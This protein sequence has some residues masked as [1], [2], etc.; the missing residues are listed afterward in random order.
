MAA[1]L[2]QFQRVRRKQRYIES[3]SAVRAKLLG[4]FAIVFSYTVRHNTDVP[5]GSDKTD[6]L[7]A[8]SLELAF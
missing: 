1:R 5:V 3:V 7:T 6:K 2:V 8:I 4:D